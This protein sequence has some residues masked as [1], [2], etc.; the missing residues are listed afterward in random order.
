[1]RMQWEIIPRLLDF[2]GGRFEKRPYKA[3]LQGVITGRPYKA[4]LQSII[5][6]L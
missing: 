6:V 2:G 4:L 5:S 3:L 1:M